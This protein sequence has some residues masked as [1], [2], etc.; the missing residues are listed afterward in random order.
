MGDD[1]AGPAVIET[2]RRQALPQNVELLD[3]GT[4]GL[5]L[6]DLMADAER[7]ILVDAVGMGVAPGTVRRFTLDQV[8]LAEHSALSLHQTGLAEVLLLGR[9]MD[10]LPP[11]LVVF[12]IQPERVERRM[13]LS[14]PVAGGVGRAVVLIREEIAQD[15]GQRGKISE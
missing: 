4:A 5:V 6:L 9:E 3:G 11:S 13:E 8:A 12:G 2:L 10:M 14:A 1:G 15:V 7:V